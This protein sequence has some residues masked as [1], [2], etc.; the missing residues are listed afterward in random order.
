M[1]AET[2]R[3][4]EFFIMGAQFMLTI[5][6]NKEHGVTVLGAQKRA[7]NRLLLEREQEAKADASHND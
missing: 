4:A 6:E 2:P 7:L 5:G 3:E 1:N